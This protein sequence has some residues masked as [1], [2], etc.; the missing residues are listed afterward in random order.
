MILKKVELD[1]NFHVGTQAELSDIEALK[2]AG[3]EM[4]I[5]NRP[6]GEVDGQPTSGEIAAAA[7]AAG[8]DYAH[9]PI[10]H[11][12][13]PSDVK[14]EIEA[15]EKAGARKTYAFCRSGTRS[16]MLWALAHHEQGRDIDELRAKAEA[17]GYSLTPINHLL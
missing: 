3:F 15:L 7:E 14:A 2:A 16:T 1:T 10:T 9:V 17:A 13:S 6:D 5:N 4:I 11:G 12:I 8:L